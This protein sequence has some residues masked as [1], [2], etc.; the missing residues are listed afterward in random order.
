MYVLEI[1]PLP[2]RHFSERN[3]LAKTKAANGQCAE[4]SQQPF[5]ALFGMSVGPTVHF[6][7][8]PVLPANNPGGDLTGQL[9]TGR[10]G[11]WC[12]PF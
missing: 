11:L 4:D 6:F 8:D 10:V 1:I 3:E 12:F 5:L 7:S 9:I 2:D